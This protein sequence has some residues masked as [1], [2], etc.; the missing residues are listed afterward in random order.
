M[1]D[2]DGGADVGGLRAERDILAAR[3]NRALDILERVRA[4]LPLTAVAAD[5]D[6]LLEECGR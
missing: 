5:S 6:T 1:I 3:L 4:M 2:Y